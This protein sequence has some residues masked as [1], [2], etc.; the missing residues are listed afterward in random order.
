M[1]TSEQDITEMR[2]TLPNL[3]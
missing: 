1:V 3:G 2:I